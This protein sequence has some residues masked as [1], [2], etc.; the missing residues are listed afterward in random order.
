MLA[1][2]DEAAILP[3]LDQVHGYERDH[4]AIFATVAML[5]IAADGASARLY[6]AGHPPPLVFGCEPLRVPAGPPLGVLDG[7]VWDAAEIALPQRWEVALFTDGVF[8]GLEEPGCAIRLGLERLGD[9][10]VEMRGKHPEPIEWIDAVIEQVLACN[11]G[12]LT[13]D[14]AIVVLTDNGPRPT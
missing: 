5:R 13:D 6:L 14:M 11:G 10:M 8:E 9:L 7:F 1:G 12:P 2:T 4:D 3:L